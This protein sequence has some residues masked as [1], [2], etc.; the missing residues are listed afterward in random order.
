MIHGIT[1]YLKG[2][3]GGGLNASIANYGAKDWIMVRDGD[4]M[5]LTEDWGERVTALTQS[6]YDLM[7]CLTNRIGTPHLL[8]GGEISDNPD[9]AYHRNIAQ[10]LTEPVV[11]PLD[12]GA[13]A[14]FFMLFQKKLWDAI[15]GFEERHNG[16][17]A[18]FTEQARAMGAR[19]GVAQSLYVFHMYR[20]GKPDPKNSFEHLL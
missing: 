15:G 7:G 20:W 4:T 3:I 10:S 2:N 14:G 1:T 8:Y 18:I 5:F 13:I 6:G 9:I 19:I 17:D 11:K 16:F 12:R